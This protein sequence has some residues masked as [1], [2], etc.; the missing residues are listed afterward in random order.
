MDQNAIGIIV[1]I[2]IS[3]LIYLGLAHRVLDRMRLSDR[4]A[5][6]VI[7]L[8]ILGGFINIPL[9]FLPF[10]TSLNVGGAL[11]PV[12]LAIYLLVRAGTRKEWVRALVGT[13]ATAAIV[14]VVGSLINSGS[15]MEPAGRWAIIDAIYLYPLV[16]G[17]VAYL[18]G[19][20]RRGA[21]ISATLGVLLVDVFQFAWLINQGAPA[22]YTMMIGGAGAFDA[23]VLAGIFAVILAELVG[24]SLERISGGPKVEGRPPELVKGLKKPE[25]GIPTEIGDKVEGPQGDKE[26]EDETK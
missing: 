18:F 13:V 19:R 8:I 24:E 21:F 6:L 10:N 25:P 26:K 14:Y 5:L 7:G 2:A 3:I 22:S 15:T 9:P 4:G 1:L 16:G 17:I 20:S 23:I 12:G 11:I